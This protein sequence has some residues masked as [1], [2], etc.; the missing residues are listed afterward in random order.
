ML[1]TGI[2]FLESH[3]QARLEGSFL[4][5]THH[6]LCLT[7]L[8]YLKTLPGRVRLQ[9]KAE[10]FESY[11]ANNWM[12]HAQMAE[13]E[14]ILHSALIEFTKWPQCPGLGLQRPWQ[15]PEHYV[16]TDT[17]QHISSAYWLHSVLAELTLRCD[18]ALDLGQPSLG[19]RTSIDARN[20]WSRTPLSNASDND[21]ANIMRLLLDT[22]KVK[23]AS[24]CTLGNTPLIYAAYKGDAVV[25]KMLLETGKAEVNSANDATQTAYY[26]AMERGHLQVVKLLLEYGDVD[27]NTACQQ[28][29]HG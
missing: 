8:C 14:D 4:G 11:S 18:Q 22:R 3:S 2:W 9:A 27:V 23:V 26:V 28:I 7:C 21:H 20:F 10:L 25:V 6:F 29:I 17:L 1:T 5:T 19:S 24:K 15:T 13:N 16:S 12:F